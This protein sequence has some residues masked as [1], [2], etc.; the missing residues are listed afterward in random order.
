MVCIE[1]SPHQA[2]HAQISLRKIDPVYLIDPTASLEIGYRQ[3]EYP[4]FAFR[5]KRY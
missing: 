2:R 5:V 1:A 4:I 3:T